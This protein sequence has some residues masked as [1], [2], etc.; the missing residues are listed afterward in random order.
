MPGDQAR[1]RSAGFL[2]AYALANAGGVL[3]YLPLLNLLLP[4]K[5]EALS[6]SMRVAALSQI[7]IG[8]ALA[9]SVGNILAGLVVD[10][11]Y[12]HGGGRR[13]WIVSGVMAT[14]LGYGLILR[15]QDTVALFAAVVV[16][17]LAANIML[18]P[19]AVVMVDEVPDAQKGLAGGL[20][21][22]GQPVAMLAAIGLVSV[23]EAG[24]G[25]AYL[26]ICLGVAVLVAPLLWS[27]PRAVA[28]G[29]AGPRGA[30]ARR[31]LV[32]VGL[33]RLLLL[34]ANS[35]LAGVL[36][37]YF[38]ALSTTLSPG[39]VAR[40]VGV[41]SLIACGAAVPV[42]VLVGAL[43]IDGARR[44]RVVLGAALLAGGALGVMGLARAWQMAALGYGLFVCAV[45]VYTS[46]HSAMVAQALR[47]TRH[48]ARDLGFQNL[49]NTVPAIIGPGLVLALYAQRDLHALIWAML[50]L[51]AGSAA[52]MA[53]VRVTGS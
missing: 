28:P 53:L 24:E 49:A 36:V 42:A 21:A 41:I 4:L 14:A 9:A 34:T 23:Y 35:L 44:R 12:A 29:G 48:R 37:Y 33:S 10:R 1:R 5:V 47:S 43:P 32:W 16:F 52:S 30:M 2:L 51:V 7:L 38:E 3:A 25:G 6:G 8:G 26:A 50:A 27:R 19:I 17:Q 11:S 13:V 31:D 18:S 39:M 46:Q 40:R 45:Q 15:A 20:L 22:L